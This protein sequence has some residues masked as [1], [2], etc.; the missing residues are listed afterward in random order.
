MFETER[1]GKTFIVT[2]KRPPVNAINGEWIDGFGAVLDA[3]AASPTTAMVIR[4]AHRQFSA[5]ADLKMLR[6]CLDSEAGVTGMIETVRR[7]QRLFDRIEALPQVVIAEISGAA[8]GGGF[9]LALACDLRVAAEDATLGLPEARLGL[10]P[11]AGGTQ[12]L[13][14]LA[15]PGVARR[16]IL[17]AEVVTGT[18]AREL[19]LVQWAVPV[20]QIAAFT[21]GLAQR[22]SSASPASLAACKR[23]FA[24]ADTDLH[25]G[26]QRELDE[27]LELFRSDDTR[28][29]V[30]AFLDR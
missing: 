4:S 28:R 2:M 5:G 3:M 8:L 17:T 23:C 14:R 13:S 16:L 20:A 29:R 15:G 30:Q 11:G 19:G 12:R 6:A 7:L 9:E 1:R 10:L 26:Q 18:Q 21:D 25:E 22:I 24:V 27:T